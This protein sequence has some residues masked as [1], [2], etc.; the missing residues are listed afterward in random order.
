MLAAVLL[1]WAAWAQPAAGK[2][3]RLGILSPGAAPDPSVPTLANTL[4]AAL[5]ELGYVEGRNLV[6]ERRFGDD[7]VERL[8]ALARE[9]VALKCDVIAGLSTQGILA[10]REATT[11]IPIVM[12]IATDP[13]AIGLVSSL[14]RPGGHI[15]G[16]SMVAETS[17]AGKRLELLKEALPKAARVVV[18]GSA[19]LASSAQLKEARKAA[20]TL[21]VKIV[22]VELRDADYDRAFATMAAEHADA[23]VVLGGPTI[24]RDRKEVVEHAAKQRL[25]IISSNPE[26][27]EVG[28][29]MS[30]GS[31]NANLASRAAVYVDK[32]LKG[33]KPAGLPVEQASTFELVINL[34]TA[35]ALNLT[36]PQSLL[37]RA[38]R[39]VR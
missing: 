7:K 17:L 39:V 30:Y 36:L 25:P 21:R 16:I 11:T 1:P 6:V 31:S 2:M 37:E 8:P 38:D 23:I 3:Y 28:A 10:A 29:L 34:K 35:K 19:P 12:V 20:D 26:L 22:P 32:I 33:A 9:L 15:T 27:T 4:P 13:V 14:G 18:F 24:I 5:R